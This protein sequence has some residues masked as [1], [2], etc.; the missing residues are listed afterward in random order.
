MTTTVQAALK[1]AIDLFDKEGF[2]EEDEIQA[3]RELC[4]SALSECKSVVEVSTKI[5]DVHAKLKSVNRNY[6]VDH[7][8]HCILDIKQSLSIPQ[9]AEWVGLSRDEKT[10]LSLQYS[11]HL[12]Y[13]LC[14]AIEAKLKKLN[15]PEK[16]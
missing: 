14:D 8:I 13:E 2:I 16:G 1:A 4:A 12:F 5:D 15:A 9:T 6:D 10:R 11:G 7:I 3:V